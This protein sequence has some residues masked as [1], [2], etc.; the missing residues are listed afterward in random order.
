MPLS[1][2]RD[3]DRKQAERAKIRLDRQLS[4]PAGANGVV[5][6]PIFHR[7]AV[8]VVL[9]NPNAKPS[10]EMMAGLDGHGADGYP[11]KDQLPPGVSYIDADGN[12]ALAYWR[13]KQEKESP[14]G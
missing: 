7:D 3:R 14:E 13:G 12:I 5:P 11:I 9:W 6:K 4:S 2:K 1:K 10:R 8:G